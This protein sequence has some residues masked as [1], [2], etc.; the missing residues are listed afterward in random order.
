MRA[1]ESDKARSKAGAKD[2]GKGKVDSLATSKPS[3]TSSAAASKDSKAVKQPSAKHSPPQKA[4]ADK[5]SRKRSRSSSRSRS[6]S[7]RNGIVPHLNG[8]DSRKKPPSA[9][10]KKQ[11]RNSS[12]QDRESRKVWM[13]SDN[14]KTHG[15]WS[16]VQLRDVLRSLEQDRHKHKVLT[17]LG[18]TASVRS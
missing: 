3:H 2:T 8:K 18:S 11:S 4:A 14:R 7:K 15:P 17:V 12:Q 6:P 1:P 10:D 5:S 13:Y 9:D 16:L